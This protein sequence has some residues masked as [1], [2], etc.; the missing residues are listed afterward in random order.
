MNKKMLLIIGCL[1]IIGGV[2]LFIFLNKDDGDKKLTITFNDNA[3]TGYQW[4]YVLSKEDIVEI[5]SKTDYSNCPKDV[6]GCGGKITFTVTP[7]K[8]GEVTINFNLTSPSD[9][10]DETVIYNIKVDNNLKISETHTNGK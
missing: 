4:K 7:L 10:V 5:T 3:S 6:D 2:L 9:E 1:L 8:E